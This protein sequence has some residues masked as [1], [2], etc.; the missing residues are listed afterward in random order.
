MADVNYV[1]KMDRIIAR[2]FEEGG[3]QVPE[4]MDYLAAAK[5][6]LNMLGIP[7]EVPLGEVI[8]ALR[9]NAN[10]Y[11]MAQDHTN[12]MMEFT[13]EDM[14]EDNMAPIPKN[15]AARRHRNRGRKRNRT[16]E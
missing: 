9:V 10:L 8:F 3:Y 1:R 14:G 13:L 7:P 6:L 12:Q 2:Y 11:K 16:T 15:R 5:D 4:D